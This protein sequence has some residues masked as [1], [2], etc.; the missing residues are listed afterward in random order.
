MTP[1]YYFLWADSPG[2]PSGSCTQGLRDR[3]QGVG[4]WRPFCKLGGESVLTSPGGWFLAAVGLRSRTFPCWL[5]AAPAE[6]PCPV[7]PPSVSQPQMACHAQEP[8]LQSL[9]PRPSCK[10]HP[11]NFP[12]EPKVNQSGTSVNP[13]RSLLQV[14]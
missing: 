11:G 8:S 2:R 9:T 10:A 3:N 14:T 7:A 4:L 1:S 6:V 13:Q 12:R 5:P